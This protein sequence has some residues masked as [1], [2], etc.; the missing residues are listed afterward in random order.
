MR[1]LF[2]LGINLV[3]IFTNISDNIP[4]IVNLYLKISVFAS[5]IVIKLVKN[6]LIFLYFYFID[7]VIF[8]YLFFILHNINSNFLLI[9]LQFSSNCLK[10]I[11]HILTK[12]L[13]IILHS[14]KYKLLIINSLF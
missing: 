8:S 4:Y 6:E 12:I 3:N 13:M 1:F 11:S 5:I 7:L 9:L 2:V 10:L 14:I